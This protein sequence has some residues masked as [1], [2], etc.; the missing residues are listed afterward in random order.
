MFCTTGGDDKAAKHPYIVQECSLLL[1]NKTD[2]LPHLPFNLQLFRDDVRRLNPSVQLLE[3]SAY[4]GDGMEP[5][6][7]WLEQQRAKYSHGLAS[8]PCQEHPSMQFCNKE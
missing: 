2:L 1:L 7:A 8:K 4:T 6:L 5:W 3:L